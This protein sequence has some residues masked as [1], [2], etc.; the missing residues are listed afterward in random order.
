MLYIL[1]YSAAQTW[2]YKLAN[3]FIVGLTWQGCI[4]EP[5]EVMSTYCANSVHNN[6]HYFIKNTAWTLMLHALL[7]KETSI[8]TQI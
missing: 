3:P 1:M 2:I 5:D 4:N 6:V 8:L 7:L